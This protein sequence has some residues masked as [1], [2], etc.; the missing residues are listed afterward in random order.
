MKV[1]KVLN[2]MMWVLLAVSAVLIVSLMSNIGEDSDP[3][4]GSWINTNLSWTYI[5]LL[6]T[7]GV[8]VIGALIH[9]FS[10]KEAAKKGLTAVVFAAVLVGI[11]YAFASD[12]IP[13]FYGVE[14]YVAD[15]SLTNTIAKWIDTT[16]IATYLLIGLVI[17]ATIVSSV[18]RI[19]K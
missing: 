12:A 17:V 8:A 14:D 5:L 15:G 2:I 19:F 11:S 7:T 18:S 16:L 9:T 6:L 3:T 1:E 4:M 10:S 13:Q